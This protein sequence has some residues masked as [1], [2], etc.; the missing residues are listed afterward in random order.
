MK[1]YLRAKL[2]NLLVRKLFNTITADDILKL[3]NQNMFLKGKRLTTEQITE[4]KENAERFADSVVWK[5]L[6]DDI[7]Y[8]ANYLM[9]EKS[10]DYQDMMFGKAILYVVDIINKR[11]K[12]ISR[13]K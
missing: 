13:L 9:Y 5:L 2:V 11:L 7:K 6:S 3:E 1:S 12:W 10:K 8:H 4:L